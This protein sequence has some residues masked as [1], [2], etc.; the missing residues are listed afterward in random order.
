MS[1]G[2]ASGVSQNTATLSGTVATNSLQTEYG[3]E[4]GTEPGNYGP[5]TGLGSIGGALTET[6]SVRLAELQ[7]GTTYYYR[8]T[9][10]N[11]DGTRQGETESF[12]TPGFPT[13]IASPASPPLIA[14]PDIAFP[15]EVRTTT[16][17][18]KVLTRAQKL[19]VALKAC[20]K[21][22][23]SKRGACQK[24]ARK[25]YAPAKKKSKKK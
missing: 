13:L 19:V 5:A 2:G 14:T 22:P 21:K 11:S 3:F 16:S 4:I 1:T 23:K 20:A 25:R 24:Q 18:P 17:M 12:T 9:A 15:G 6:V 8:V 10:T 7:P